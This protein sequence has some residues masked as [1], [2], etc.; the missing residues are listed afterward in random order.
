MKPWYYASIMCDVRPI[1]LTCSSNVSTKFSV[2]WGSR[3]NKTRRKRKIITK[4]LKKNIFCHLQFAAMFYLHCL[5]WNISTFQLKLLFAALF[6]YSTRLVQ[7]QH[8]SE[9]AVAPSSLEYNNGPRTP[10]S[11]VALARNKLK[12]APELHV[13]NTALQ[14]GAAGLSSY[15]SCA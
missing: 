15:I 9:V 5:C 10:Q 3:F 4:L 7:L 14:N 6:V 8:T 12:V 11:G 1:K 13:R 2:V